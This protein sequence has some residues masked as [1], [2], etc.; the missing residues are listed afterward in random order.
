M[1]LKP[2]RSQ[3]PGARPTD[4]LRAARGIMIAVAVAG[5]LWVLALGI[6]KLLH[7]SI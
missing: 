5:L 6:L 4:K 2:D 3:R 1:R 7:S